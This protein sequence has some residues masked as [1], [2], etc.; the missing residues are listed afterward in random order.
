MEVDV[1]VD[2]DAALLIRST[3]LSYA[4]RKR[5]LLFTGSGFVGFCGINLFNRVNSV[6][7][8]NI[9][10]HRLLV[11]V[12]RQAELV[13]PILRENRRSGCLGLCAFGERAL[14]NLSCGQVEGYQ[15]FAIGVDEFAEKFISVI[16]VPTHKFHDFGKEQF[17]GYRLGFAFSFAGF[18]TP[19]K[20]IARTFVTRA[21]S[22]DFSLAVYKYL[23]VPGVREL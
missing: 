4:N 12:I 13:L 6:P 9:D 17:A 11:F 7:V 5:R 14:I 16:G 22:E 21:K 15:V 20:G 2:V 10:L 18:G 23:C 1:E 8:K 19:H 3:S